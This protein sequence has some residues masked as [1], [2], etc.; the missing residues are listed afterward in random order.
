MNRHVTMPETPAAK[1]SNPPPT[2]AGRYSLVV[3]TRPAIRRRPTLVGMPK[4]E[5]APR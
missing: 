1:K 3:K 2:T 5:G 4:V